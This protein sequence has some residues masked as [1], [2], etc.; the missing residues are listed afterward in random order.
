MNLVNSL[1]LTCPIGNSVSASAR[2]FLHNPKSD[3]KIGIDEGMELDSAEI[4]SDEGAELG[5]SD[6]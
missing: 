2:Y 3:K 4:C 1:A 5:S 6:R